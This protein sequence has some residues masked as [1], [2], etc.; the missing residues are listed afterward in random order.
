MRELVS[1]DRNSYVPTRA[2][3]S[4]IEYTYT[5]LYGNT[6]TINT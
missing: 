4:V 5:L 6:I 3:N 1:A 2:T